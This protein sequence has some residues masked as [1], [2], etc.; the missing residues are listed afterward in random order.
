MAFNANFQTRHVLKVN[1]F[2]SSDTDTDRIFRN[3]QL[4]CWPS[5][6]YFG[7]ARLACNPLFSIKWF[8]PIFLASLKRRNKRQPGMDR[9]NLR[10]INAR[11]CGAESSTTTSRYSD[12]N[13]LHFLEYSFGCIFFCQRVACKEWK[14]VR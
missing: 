9:S 6:V 5:F 4:I 7:I 1:N 2:C 3:N 14:C 13:L 10:S 12:A 8:C 11:S